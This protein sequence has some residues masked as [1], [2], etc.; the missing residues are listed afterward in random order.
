MSEIEQT[1][2]D[3]TF[4]QEIILEQYRQAHEQ[5]AR[6]ADIQW[7]VMGLGNTLVGG[8]LIAALTNDNTI[9][10]MFLS[11]AAIPISFYIY[12]AYRKG[13]YFENMYSENIEA[14]ESYIGKLKHV[15]YDSLP[16]SD[17]NKYYV[18]VKPR[19]WSVERFS[20]YTIMTILT[21][22]FTLGAMIMFFYFGRY[23]LLTW[24]LILIIVIIFPFLYF[25]TMLLNTTTRT[26]KH[27]QRYN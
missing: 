4:R 24:A 27:V 14:M 3:V 21:A 2:K 15:Q 12:I 8:I 23:V 25:L 7:K 11:F 20:Q 6:D 9:V 17:D 18:T 10:S 1:Q 5:R 16:Q 19:K 26:K 22:S 13:L